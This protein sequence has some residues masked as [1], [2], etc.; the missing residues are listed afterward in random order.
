MPNPAT[1]SEKNPT[2][3]RSYFRRA[4]RNFRKARDEAKANP[5]P[6]TVSRRR[7]RT[8]AAW[9]VSRKLRAVVLASGGTSLRGAA[10]LGAIRKAVRSYRLALASWRGYYNAGHT[11]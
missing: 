8:L 3:V 10:K 7:D 9:S 2:R 5:N 1:I 6:G 11:L 4:V